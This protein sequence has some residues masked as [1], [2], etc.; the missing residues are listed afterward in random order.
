MATTDLLLEGR[1]FRRD[2]SPAY[3][4]GRKAAAANLADV[5]AV[6]AAPTALLV[7]FAAPADLP[8]EWADGFSDGLRDECAVVGASVAG[9]DVSVADA[10]VLGITALG[11]LGGQAPVTRGGGRPGD[12]VAV[13]GRLGWA[14]AGYSVLSRGFRSPGSLVAAHRRPE[15]PYPAGP[16]AARLG[17]TAMSDVSDGLIAD[18]GHI[19]DASGVRIDIDSAVFEV[20]QP[21]ADVAGAL[22]VDPRSWILN[23]GDDHALAATF[24]AGTPLDDEWL[25][26]GH[27]AGGEGVY[28]DGRPYAGDAGWQHFR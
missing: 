15:P 6:G 9:G 11:D 18:L 24:P 28:V 23:G 17:A 14:A 1:H 10:I 12:V 16:A 25:V 5:A 13:A 27:V 20:P 22:G 2:W 3:D 8:T 4:V 7:G 21:F 26:A 19:A